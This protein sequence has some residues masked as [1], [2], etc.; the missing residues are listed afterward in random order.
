MTD[1]SCNHLFVYGTLK[2]GQ[3]NHHLIE[4]LVDDI[5][6]AKTRGILYHLPYGFPAVFQSDKNW[7]YG[8][9]FNLSDIKGSLAITDHLEGYSANKPRGSHYIRIQQQVVLKDGN[10]QI[11][12]IYIYPRNRFS[13]V[14]RV[15]T[16][17]ESGC[18]DTVTS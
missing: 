6:P 1:N 3:R 13:D 17:I 15:G 5:Q 18:W 14:L 8:E 10:C 12:W 16:L 9:L 2:R 7:V 11:A 4:H